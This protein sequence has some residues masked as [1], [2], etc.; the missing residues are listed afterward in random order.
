MVGGS[1]VSVLAADD[2]MFVPSGTAT[3]MPTTIG[4]WIVWRPP[5]GGSSGGSSATSDSAGDQGYVRVLRPAINASLAAGGATDVGDVEETEPRSTSA[6]AATATWTT[7]V[8]ATS[9]DD[10]ILRESSS[11]DRMRL[12]LRASKLYEITV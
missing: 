4:V 8:Q 7:V 6:A 3:T 5:G 12:E 2:G 10:F 1:S 9:S 11:G